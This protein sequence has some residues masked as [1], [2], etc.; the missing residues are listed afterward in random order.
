[1]LEHVKQVVRYRE[2]VR[3]LTVRDLK[4]R[5]RNSLLGFFWAWGNP[6]LMT[7]VF[8]VVFTV[9]QKS[10]I[11][12]F[13]LFILIGWLVWGFTSSSIT[14]G[15]SSVVGSSTLIKKIYFPR[16]VLPASSI[17][18]NAANFMLALP[19]VL[20]L[21][22]YYQINVDVPLLVYFPVIFL[23]QLALVM[24]IAFFLSA[25]NV[26]YRDTGV[27]TGVLLTAWFF[28]TPV[29]Y[30]VGRVTGTWHGI[31]LGRLWYILNPMASIIES[32]RSIFYGSVDGGPPGP[33]NFEFLA[34][35]LVT[36]FAI[37][38]AGYL[39]FIRLSHRFG[40]EL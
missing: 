26:F 24:G 1:M 37:L 15:I 28:L 9:L 5:Y 23:G 35:A 39:V 19:L 32:Y 7:A 29:F 33:P 22:L 27:I 38:I 30:S 20:I 8:S 17:L 6:V 11:I 16:E 21:M 25:L 40:E 14:E 12:H 2:L 18:A 13:P 3:N 10:P 36:C 31:D 4:V 34:R